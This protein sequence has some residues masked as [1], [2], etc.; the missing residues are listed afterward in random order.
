M[1]CSLVCLHVQTVAGIWTACMDMRSPQRME[2][3]TDFIQVQ[4]GTEIKKVYKE[5]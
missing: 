4:A 1:T 3:F 5:K 2:A